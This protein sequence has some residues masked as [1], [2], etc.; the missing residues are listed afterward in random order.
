[1]LVSQGEYWN[2]GESADPATDRPCNATPIRA[3][4]GVT[5][6]ADITFNGYA[7]GVQFTPIVSAYLTD[8][9]KN[10]RSAAGVFETTAFIWDQSKGFEVLPPEVVANNGSMTRNGQWMTVNVDFDGDG[11]SQ[12]ALRASNG[13]VIS[14]GDLNRDTCGGSSA[15]GVASSYGWAVDD[16]GRTAVG[17]AYVDRDGDGSCESPN[18]ARSCRSSGRRGRAC[19]RS[20][21]GTCPWTSCRGSARTRFPATARS[22]SARPTSSTPTPG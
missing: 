20:I 16:T 19:A 4:A 22:C 5:K 10:G 2:T 1:M 7:Q 18:R 14:L 21:P 8:L 9:A 15:N 3:Q 11:I 17:T 13:S 12:A 6:T